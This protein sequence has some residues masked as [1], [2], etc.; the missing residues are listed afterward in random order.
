MLR[1][2]LAF[3]LHVGSGRSASDR[4]D[5]I[6]L[7]MRDF[8]FLARHRLLKVFQLCCLLIDRP[9]SI[10]LF[11]TIDLSGC[12]MDAKIFRDRLLMEQ[13]Y[14][15]SPGYAHKSFFTVPTLDAAREA[16]AGAGQFFVAPTS[17]LCLGFVLPITTTSFSGTKSSM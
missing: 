8:S 2:W 10:L 16:S 1:R 7:L 4:G 5:V 3:L 17:D 14:V 6:G 15:L 12:A 11:V 13:S 9:R